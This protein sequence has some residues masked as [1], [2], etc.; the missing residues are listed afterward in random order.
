MTGDYTI[1]RVFTAT[2][3]C[4]NSTSATQT[5]TIIDTTAPVLTIPSDYTAECSDDHPMDD[6]SA[7]DNCGEVTID[8]VDT[9]IAGACEGDYTISRLFTA[10]DDC[11]NSSSATQIITIIDTTAPVLT[12]PSDYTAECSDDHPMDDAS[13]SDSCGEVIISV[14]ATITPG[15]CT[16]DYTITRV[17]T[18][19]DDCGNATSATQ[20]ITIIDTTAPVLTIPSDYTAE[21]SDDHPMDDAS[22]TDNCGEVTIDVVDTTIAGACEGDYT[23]SRLFTATDDCGNSTSATQTITIIDTTAPVLTIPSDYTAECSDD[24]PMDDASATDNCGEVTIDVVDTTIA[25]ACEGD[26]TISRLF[27]A[28]DDCGNSTSATQTITIIDTTA[29]VLTIPSDYTAECSDNHPM[30]DASATDNCGNVEITLNEYSIAGNADGNYIITRVFTATDDCGN[31]ASATQTI[32][33]ADTTA[34]DITPPADYTMECGSEIILDD[35]SV[36]DNCSEVTMTV[37]SVTVNGICG[38][39][40]NL[41]RTFTAT[42][43]A[44]NASSVTQVI[45]VLDTTGPVFTYVE[46]GEALTLNES[47]GDVLNNDPIVLIVDGCDNSPLW[48]YE[49]VVLEIDGPTTTIQRTFTAVDDCGN[50]STFVQIIVFT[51]NVEGCTDENACNYNPSANSDDDSCLY[52]LFAYDCD[53]SCLN[54]DNGNGI[55]DELE[56]SGCMDITNPG[57]NPLANINDDGSCLAGGCVLP[58]ACN[59]D[60]DAEYMIEGACEFSSCAGCTNPSACNYDSILSIDDGS[61]YY[62]DYAYDCDGNCLNDDNGNGICDELEI[63][64]CMDITNPGYNPLANTDD[65]SC[66]VGG[67]VLPFACNYDVDAEYMIEG[68]CEFSSCAGCTNPSACNY[69]SILSIDDG[70]CYY[71]D[72]AYDCDGNCLNDDNGNGICDELEISGCMDIT[73]P[74]YNPLANTD[75]GSCLVGGCVLPF[76]C[77]YDVD[78]E[79][80]IEGACEFSSCAGC[81][82][83]S[84]CNYDSILSIDDGSCYYADYAYDCDGNCLNDDNGNGICDELEI[85]GCMDI[86]NPGYNPLANTDDG[87]C[88]VGGCVLPFAC[89]YDVD[90]E[91]M[92]EG[93]CEFSSCAGCTNPSACNYDSILSIDDGSC[94]YS[95]Y[96]Y[97]CDG[98]CLNDDNG[99]GICDELEILGCMDITNPGYN[100]LANTDDGSCLVAGCLIPFACNYDPNADYLLVE[101]CDFTTCVGCMDETSCTY[102]PSAT[103]SAPGDCTYPVNQFVDCDGFCNNDIDGDGICDELE[104]FGCTDIAASN[105]NPNATEDDGSCI[106][107]VGGCSLPFACNYDPLVDFYIP[108]SCDFSCLFGMPGGEA[109]A[110]PLACNYG[111]L[112][113]CNYFDANGNLC[114]TLGCMNEVACNYNPDAELQDS[115][116]YTSCI[117][118]GCTN[119][120]ACNYD[121]IATTDNGSCVY[122]TC[123]GCTDNLASNFDPAATLDN[124]N[125]LYDVL[126]CMNMMSCNY[127]PNAT[128]SD[129]NCDL[130]SCYGCMINTACNYDVDVTIPDGTCEFAN[131]GHDCAGDCL[132]DSDSDGI[133]NENEVV[134]C[135]IS[136]ASNYNPAATDDD[137]SC[138]YPSFGCTTDTACNFDWQA[139]FDDGTC[140]FTTCSGCIAP[141]ACNYDSVATLS[142]GS[143]VFADASG[144]C[145]TLCDSDVDGDGICD[146]DEVPGCIYEKALNFDAFA[147][148]DDGSCIFFGCLS[149]E[150]NNYNKYAN[151]NSNDCTNTPMNADFNSDGI[152]QLEDLLEFLISYGQAGPNWSIGWVDEACGV[153]PDA[154]AEVFDANANGCT[155]PTASN[156]DPEATMDLGNCVFTGCTDS[157]ALNYNHLANMEDSSCTYQVCPDFNGDG[158]V[159]TLDL[160]DFL[161]VWGTE[162][163]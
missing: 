47:D 26:Y 151:T 18:A 100:P 154:L 17:F 114:A 126:G 145:P 127:D 99:N 86:T 43:E 160:L 52:P 16:G 90:A 70:S 24:H 117:I 155:Y 35:A 75:D 91:Y 9:T 118:Y 159:Q 96:P 7:T 121:S 1:T 148:D 125:C 53:G 137:G 88:L 66:L 104:V 10:T 144:L 157:E 32:T 94:Y 29:P 85:S 107:Q 161:L 31:F 79:Y 143:C 20:T 36:T 111:D 133:C 11:G 109:C 95:V 81:T 113:A 83:P 89:N 72:Y 112:A 73:N 74:G 122:D 152:V 141:S 110:D 92:I 116:D 77:N 34:P 55:C 33:V 38:V 156:Y 93:A 12:I 82:N 120:V 132:A 69:D 48:S 135:T 5:I 45:S 8:V 27:T 68:A 128:V 97:D 51:E 13:A 54:D 40:Y 119:D 61:C 76:A 129:G 131:A 42:D 3:D 150:Y 22:A 115:C 162:Y 105:Y 21:C 139:S 124:S 14:E 39:N 50:S 108:G 30:D 23:I 138:L 80:M 153:V 46:G 134:G 130:V 106:V 149:D 147:T 44:G 28:T 25:G 71:A 140:D 158:V 65:G 63:L 146:A 136:T 19:T 103:I 84:A 37:T 56:I 60:V 87:S 62:A 57:Y 98:N 123:Y 2:D 101:L 67:C 64:G 6:A 142:D 59:Y 78:A 58:F 49:D 41:L 163:E 102:D 15:S 4:G